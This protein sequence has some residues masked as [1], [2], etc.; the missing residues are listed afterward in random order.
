MPRYL[1]PTYTFP[2]DDEL[3]LSEEGWYLPRRRV[4]NSLRWV[5]LGVAALLFSGMA[6][7]GAQAVLEW[8]ESDQACLSCHTPQHRAYVER[9]QVAMGGAI[10]PDL[11]SYHY[12]HLHGIGET[13]RCIDC[14]RGNGS[15]RARAETLWLSAHMAARWLAGADDRRI[16]KTAITATVVNGVTQTTAPTALALHVPHLSNEGCAQCHMDTL[17][18]V[19]MDNHTHN[20]LPAAYRLW[21]EG[22]PLRLPRGMSEAEGALLIARG[23]TLYT[24]TL[25]C[26]SCHQ[27]H[28]S[29]DT[30]RYLDWRNVVKPACE[31]CHREVGAGPQEVTVPEE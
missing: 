16:E 20:M 11:A 9:A 31:R 7:G 28:R 6:L 1:P 17:L 25:Q 13:L 2:D 3:N 8:Q 24:T 14:H 27:A 29:L 5:G 26:S 18:R 10:A 23:L 4:P 30:P 15:T 22:A 19:G 21:L 12:Q